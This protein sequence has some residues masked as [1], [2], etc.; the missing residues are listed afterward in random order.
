MPGHSAAAMTA[1][2]EFSCNPSGGHTVWS[3]GGISTDIINVANPAA[4]QFAKDVLEEI[5]E[6][7][8]GKHIHIGGDECPTD[9]WEK[10]LNAK[11]STKS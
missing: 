6:L 2:P 9:A 3:K 4:V 10:M 5:M 7:F 1:Y 11:H 8:P